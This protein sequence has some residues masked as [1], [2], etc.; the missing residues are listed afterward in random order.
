MPRNPR[1]RTQTDAPSPHSL[2]QYALLADGERG[3]VIGPDGSVVWMC[4]PRWDSPAVF[5]TLIGGPGFYRVTPEER[6]VWG[7]RYEAATLIWRSRWVTTSGVV[8]CREA[9]GFP[10]RPDRALLLRRLCV[11]EGRT[12]VGVTLHLRSGY[13]QDPLRQLRQHDDGSW[14][15]TT[16]DVL[17]RW[18]GMPN[19]RVTPDGHR[20]HLL[21][22]TL[23]LS[24][25][26]ERGLVLELTTR[27]FDDPA[28]DADEAWDAT[29]HHWAA[30]V[31]PTG[32]LVAQRD[33]EHAYAVLAGLTSQG[34]MV[35]AATTS[36]PER[37]EAGR[38]Y[39]YRYV[40]IRDQ[41]L[42]GLAVAAL[43][44][45]PLLDDAVRVVQ[46]H[47]LADGPGLVP[48]YT[49]D[50]D[51]VPQER[52][53]DLPGYPGGTDIIGNRVRGQHQLDT[54]GEALLLFAAAARHGHLD[55]DGWRA[56]EVA[57]DA[58]G[59]L[60]NE[61]DG[62]V[63]ELDDNWWT[64]SR[65]ECVAGLRAIGA[66]PG[67]PPRAA[68]EW[69]ASADAILHE[70]SRT[71][72]HP[73]GR[74][75]RAPDDDRV[76]AALLVPALRGAL[77]PD[78]PRTAATLAAVRTDLSEDGY[79]YRF[80]HDA[81]PLGDAEGAFLL[82]GFWMSLA[83]LHHGDTLEA[84]RWFERNRAA[85]GPPGLY[86]EEFDVAQRQLRGNL[87]QAFVHAAMLE[88]AIRLSANDHLS[89]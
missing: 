85:C 37:A 44:P 15:A 81:R 52:S 27:P 62:G 19:A 38:S 61:P 4:F 22:G 64:H 40:W 16:G 87:P 23:M 9:L 7:G 84:V 68:S 76:D 51:P 73:S 11:V 56:A 72:S 24:A 83:C 28:A 45:R 3:A 55:V 65:L 2:R 60:W 63:W 25:G 57:V 59:R 54:F 30:V 79:L 12:T 74:W 31:P 82:C 6:F 69:T 78:D 46:S 71:C 1:A 42:A 20:G 86:A 21:E 75:Q 13:G 43:G 47:L 39:D 8:E 36:L 50:G 80:A 89:P 35:A 29:E 18:S 77:P 66:A 67:A 10:A 17:L 41:C 5:S 88:T 26:D 14:T 48:A 53:L 32:Q 58:I 70:V 49:T 34:G 33:A